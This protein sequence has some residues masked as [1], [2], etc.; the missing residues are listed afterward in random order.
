MNSALL[1]AWV[2]KFIRD[3]L[4]D[5]QFYG[6]II[7]HI[8]DGCILRTEINQMVKAPVNEESRALRKA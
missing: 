3:T 6:K 1:P 4:E 7:L 2:E 8:G 5:R